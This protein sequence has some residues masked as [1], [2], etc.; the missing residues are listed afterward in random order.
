MN[1]KG[2]YEVFFKRVM[3]FMLSSLA[4]FLLSPLILFVAILVR[5]KLGSPVI[6][7]QARPGLNEKIINIFKFRTMNNNRDESGNLLPDEVRL[8][9][10]GKFLRSTSL[11]EL[12]SLVN[13]VIGNLSIVGPRP[14]MIEYLDYYY[15]HERKRH[16]VR[17]G[18]TGLA[19]ISGRNFMTW[20]EKF[21][22]DLEYVQ[23]ITFL[24]DL[25]I[26]LITIVKVLSRTNIETGT[27]IERDGIVYRPLNVERNKIGKS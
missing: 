2:M 9:K 23:K 15:P 3:D 19:Q 7:K 26:I 25:K 18:L 8:T 27:F 12:P 6:F 5:L 20:E 11:D 13:V 16:S 21:K 22:K 1:K 10:F 4:L 24:H 14:L 17:P